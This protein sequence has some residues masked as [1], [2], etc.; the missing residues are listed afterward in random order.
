MEAR[1]IA[2]YVRVSPRKARIVVDK[3]RG[4]EVIDALD[5]LRFNERAVSETVAKVVNSAAANAQNKYGSGEPGHQRNVR[6]R[7]ADHEAL[8]PPCEGLRKPHPPAYEP[9]YRHRCTAR[10]GVEHGPES[11]ADWFPSGDHRELAQPLVR[12]QGLCRNA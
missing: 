5:I 8:P 12:R 10:G 11:Q 3:I 9:H 2:R 4:K 6:R 7:G 1:A